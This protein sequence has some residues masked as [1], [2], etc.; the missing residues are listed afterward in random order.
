MMNKQKLLALEKNDNRTRYSGMKAHMTK[1]ITVTPNTAI[2][3]FV[4]VEALANQDNI[5]AK[6]SFEF[7]CGKGINVAKAITSLDMS[8]TCLGFVGNQ[9]TSAF[10]MIHSPL[11]QT[12]F[13][14]CEGKTR[15]NITLFDSLDNRETHIRTAGFEVTADDCRKLVEKLDNCATTG[16]IVILSGSLPSGTPKNFYQIL[17]EL[18]HKNSAI[19]FLDSSGNSLQKGLTAKP[20]LIKPNQYELEE[21][22]DKPLPDE[23]S[24]VAAA[25]SIVDQG[26]KW[27]YVSRAEKGVMVISDTTVLNAGINPLP[28]Q[29]VSH[30]GCGDAMVAGLAVATLKEATL[31]AIIKTGVSSAVANLFSIEPGRF[32]RTLQADL[33]AHAV[34]M[35]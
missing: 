32:V 16:D 7:A 33:S 35:D 34:C 22:V 24:I 11:L 27:V 20:F 2:D 26:I 21:I 6:S 17:I 1:I 25:R 23:K 5:Q 29:V 3:L 13:T 12:D 10:E 15:T 14:L 9:S 19:P 8:V 18:C 28:G 31:E 30:I 4:E